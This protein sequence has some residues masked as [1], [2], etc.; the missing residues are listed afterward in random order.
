MNDW[1]LVDS[2]CHL[3]DAAFEGDRENVLARSLAALAWLVVV[4]E[5]LESSHLAA[6]M[7]GD[8]VF[9]SVGIHPHHAEQACPAALETL[10]RLA[11]AHPN[12]VAVGETGYDFYYDNAPREAQR[13][14]FR[15]QV[16][17]AAEMG[18]P[19]VVHSRAA[20]AETSA[21]FDEFKRDL[22][23]GV[24]HC[25]SGDRA[26]AERC[27]EFGFYISFAGNV[28]FPNAD[29]LRDAV[30]NVP[31]ERLLLETDSPYLS[32]QPVRG[33]RCEPAYV[34]YTA[35]TL[36]TLKGVPAAVLAE[37]TTRNA[38]ALFQRAP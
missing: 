37:Q 13:T 3:Q 21:V 27:I 8:R 7:T 33:K 16:R 6:S 12:V 28:T 14:A 9:A 1:L 15:S 35:Q 26:F 10:G 4:G 32:P 36:A 23:R 38:T 20:E 2:H 19:L 22:P 30:R 17:L 24:M 29:A 18:L 11:R 31:M 25:F 5:D 34:L